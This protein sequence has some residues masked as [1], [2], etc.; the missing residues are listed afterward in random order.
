MKIIGIG[1]GSETIINPLVEAGFE[2]NIYTV[3]S[4]R[5]DFEKSKAKHIIKIGETITY[6]LGTAGD[7]LT[8]K[9]IARESEKELKVLSSGAETFILISYLGGG[10][11]SAVTGEIARSI[12]EINSEALIISFL[13]TPFKLGGIKVA[14][15]SEVAIKDITENTDADVIFSQETIAPNTMDFKRA[16]VIIAKHIT[17]LIAD[18]SALKTIQ[19]SDLSNIFKEDIR[20]KNFITVSIKEEEEKRQAVR[21]A[22]LYKSAILLAIKEGISEQE[23][24]EIT[25][26]PNKTDYD[27]F[28]AL[29]KMIHRTRKLYRRNV[30]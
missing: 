27:K 3:S 9:R 2:N 15:C 5:Y 18:I 11:G 7:I 26:Q 12:K 8:G 19:P 14:Y 28:C 25:N 13:I 22:E 10:F 24:T 16:G 17:E 4:A 21:N 1:S 6:G 29:I 30:C 23:L 20:A